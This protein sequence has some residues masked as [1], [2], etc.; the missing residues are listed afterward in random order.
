MTPPL[1]SRRHVWVDCSGGYTYPG[2]VMAWRR[3]PAGWEAQVAVARAR[4]ISVQW[5]PAGALHL[6]TDD[7]WST[8]PAH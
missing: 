3:G 5:T 7:G 2:L 6:V 8:R 1:P 4:T